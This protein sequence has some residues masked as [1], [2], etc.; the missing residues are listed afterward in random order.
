VT[1]NAISV[2]SDAPSLWRDPILV[3]PLV[4]AAGLAVGWAGLHAGV[5]GGRVAADLAV[6]W[7]FVTASVVALPRAYWR[8]TQILFAV[9]GLA[10][11]AA[12][13]QWSG[14][15]GLWTVGL[16]LEWVWLAVVVHLVLTFPDGRPWSRVALATIG[17][18]YLAAAVG[19]L[20][21]AVVETDGR[22]ALSV[23]ASQRAADTIGRVRAGIGCAVAISVLVLVLWRLSS[24]SRPARRA[25]APML[26][27][28]AL[29]FPLMAVSLT[30]LALSD[31]DP[32]TAV[33]TVARAM[34]GLIPLGFLAGIAGSRLRG[35]QAG[36]L[37]V[38][39]RSEG[40]LTLRE[41]L[42]RTLGDPTLELAYRL[43]DGSYVDDSG[44]TVLLP[45]DP[46][47]VVT[48]LRAGDE[49]LA[50]LVHDPA[51]LDEPALVESV[52][53]STE[54]VLENERLAAEVR[55]QLAQVRASRAR[56]VAATDEE[57]RRIERDLHDGAQQR[58]VG[59]CVALG[60]AAGHTTGAA[61]QSLLRAQDDLEEAI[62]E[63]RALAR[64]I[65]PTILREE[66]LSAAIDGLARRAP[67]AVRVQGSI[68]TRLD[69]AVELAAYFV[70]CEAL[71]NVTKHSHAS[72]ATVEI[73]HADGSLSLAVSDNGRGGAQTATGGGLAG[74]RDRIEALDGW[75][76]TESA[77]DGGTT[78][79]AEIPCAS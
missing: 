24:I 31:R 42:A 10:L 56:L 14:V 65:H 33:D 8:R 74:L 63:L 39:L 20:A 75:L 18:G 5:S 36:G 2:P 4:V 67:L 48:Q 30:G 60:L 7:L 66:G 51:L 26:A 6:S 38:Q 79:R 16:L 55:V 61:K 70:V 34:M 76:R 40:A 53:A 43:R 52:R 46:A 47:R 44:R 72:A 69:P 50:A 59:L 64:G 58:L 22:D 27:G 35:T 32:T 12:D 37:I 25:Q 49:V 23:L 41:R 13:L 17:V 1:S 71:T 54:L 19:G 78:V 62:A 77:A 73:A 15:A 45:D 9:A 57:R 21:A 68:D 11:L 3:L 29:A 28:A